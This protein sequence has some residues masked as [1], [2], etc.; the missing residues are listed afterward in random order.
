[1]K[2]SLKNEVSIRFSKES[3]SIDLAGDCVS[4]RLFALEYNFEYNTKYLKRISAIDFCPFCGEHLI[5]K[6]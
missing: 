6:N 4:W 2:K 3:E 5:T 1:M